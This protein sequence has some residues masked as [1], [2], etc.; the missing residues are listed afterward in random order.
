MAQ[1][2]RHSTNTTDGQGGFGNG[3]GVSAVKMGGMRSLRLVR[4]FSY[5]ETP[6][7]PNKY[8]LSGGFR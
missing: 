3:L 7:F 1:A 4:A 8:I 5:A 2:R 6:N